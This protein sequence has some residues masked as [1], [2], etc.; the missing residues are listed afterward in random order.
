MKESLK[1]AAIRIFTAGLPSGKTATCRT[2][3]SVFK[4]ID[5]KL[6]YGDGN[7]IFAVDTS[8]IDSA[9]AAAL[10]PVPVKGALESGAY[11][12]FTLDQTYLYYTDRASHR[13]LMT[14]R[15]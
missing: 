4:W 6:Y 8:Q 2:L 11:S 14:L 15:Q 10:T 7:A 1:T 12:D 3:A 9:G 5:G 13:V